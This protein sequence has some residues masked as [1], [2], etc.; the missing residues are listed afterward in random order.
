MSY[1][2]MGFVALLAGFRSLAFRRRQLSAAPISSSLII[3]RP[4]FLGVLGWTGIAA[5]LFLLV[6]GIVILAQN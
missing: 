5:G 6:G 1:L 3:I 2:I 4:V